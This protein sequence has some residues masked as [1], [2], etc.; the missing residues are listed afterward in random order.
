MNQDSY[1]PDDK[2]TPVFNEL[3]QNQ[4]HTPRPNRKK[5]VLLAVI[6]VG[7]AAI[8]G[9]IIYMYVASQHTATPGVSASKQ[10]AK[11]EKATTDLVTYTNTEAGFSILAPK[12]M[13][14]ELEADP[15]LPGSYSV[16]G[17]TGT[18]STG[19]RFINIYR[20]KFPDVLSVGYQQWLDE[21]IEHV[22]SSL[23]AAEE[24]WPEGIKGSIPYQSTTYVGEYQAYRID[25]TI[26]TQP[27]KAGGS[28]YT[29][30]EKD[31]SVYI[32]PTTSYFIE[33]RGNDRDVWFKDNASAIVRS[34][35]VL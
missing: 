31:L 11:P 4:A 2:V 8:G 5:L 27:R 1:I 12:D 26:V 9:A 33:I 35:T 15:E 16:R 23:R 32:D 6:T 19:N 29:K 10:Q 20:Y 17:G 30:F 13:K 24:A 25:S 28:V 3:P 34:F 14:L 7:L 22:D 18:E 21:Q